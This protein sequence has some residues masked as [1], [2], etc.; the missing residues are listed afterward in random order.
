MA[1]QKEF[2]LLRLAHTVANAK[3]KAELLTDEL[4][5]N[6]TVEFLVFLVWSQLN[7]T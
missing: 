2:C 6:E 4:F 7:V 3:L 5:L 1:F